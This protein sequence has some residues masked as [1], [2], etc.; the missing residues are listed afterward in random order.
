MLHKP[1][2]QQHKN[3]N[4]LTYSSTA[5]FLKYRMLPED[6]IKPKH[7]EAYNVFYI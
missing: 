7:V 3:F 4:V 6:G 1:A 5:G 2:S